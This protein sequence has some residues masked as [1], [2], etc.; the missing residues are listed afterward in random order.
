MP[1]R[2]TLL[3][4]LIPLCI[5]TA[6]N[7]ADHSGPEKAQPPAAGSGAAEPQQLEE[8]SVIGTVNPEDFK[9]RDK[10]PIVKL[11]E[12]LDKHGKSNLP[13]FVESSNADGSRSVKVTTSGRTYWVDGPSGKIDFS[14]INQSKVATNCW[15]GCK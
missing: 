14:G 9:K 6:A 10:K 12:F 11:R 7:A 13:V 3:L 8:I 5:A 1:R 4:L 2:S 15:G